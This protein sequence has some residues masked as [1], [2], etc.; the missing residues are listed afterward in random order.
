[1]HIHQLRH[2]GA[3]ALGLMVAMIVF[4]W[5][6]ALPPQEFDLAPVVGQVTCA[7]H[8]AGELGVFFEP[9]DGRSPYASGRV[10]ADGSFR[11]LYTNGLPESEGVIPGKYRVFFC[12]L[13]PAQHG[14]SI[15]S[16]YLRPGTSDLLVDVGRD[17]NY[18]S[19]SLH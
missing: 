6:Y 5:A 11:H 13:N 16:K 14:P 9:V 8:P 18:V 19:L 15:D 12:L 2:Y 10:L 7:N 4:G 17:W 1:M 3:G